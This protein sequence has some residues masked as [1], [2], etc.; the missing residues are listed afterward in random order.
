MRRI[1]DR[2]GQETLVPSALDVVMPTDLVNKAKLAGKCKTVDLSVNIF[3]FFT[4]SVI[5]I[6]TL[7]P[8]NYN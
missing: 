5:G 3:D 6:T 7:G 2:G 8:M 4:L 1:G